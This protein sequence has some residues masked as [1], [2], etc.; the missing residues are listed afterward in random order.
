MN[1]S[2]EAILLERLKYG[3]V[4]LLLGFDYFVDV[5]SF[6][7][8]LKLISE[9]VGEDI[10][11]YTELFRHGDSISTENRF[12]K[13]K[14]NIDLIPTNNV[15]DKLSL[16]KWN[17]VYTSSVDDLILSRLKNEG[18]TTRPVCNNSKFFSYSRSELC[19]F[20]LFGL[21]SRHDALEKVPS[22]RNEF[23]KRKHESQLMLDTLADSMSPLDTL[24]ISGWNPDTDPVSSEHLYQV[25]SK[26]SQEQAYIFGKGEILQDELVDSLVEE[27]KIIKFE[28]TL[29]DFIS[30]NE[31]H[32]IDLSGHSDDLDSFIRVN[33]RPLEIPSRIRRTLNN[34]GEIVEDKFFNC[35][36]KNHESNDLLKDFLFESSRSPVWKAYPL[37][38]D[39]ER[40]Y[41]SS[42][43]SLVSDELKKNKVS[44]S[45]IILHGATGTGKSISL[46]RLCYILYNQNKYLILHI[47]NQVDTLDFKVIDEVCEW[48]ESSAGLITVICW[49]G[50]SNIDTYQNL[51]SY[52]SSRG[53]KQLVI[54]TTYKNESSNARRYINAPEQ[55]TAKEN[56]E[57]LRYLDR[58]KIS[59]ETKLIEFDSTFL[60]TLYR[61]LPETRFSITSGVV[62]EANH[63]KQL[64]SKSIKI[65][66]SCE[67]IIAEA[68]RKAFK[69]NGTILNSYLNYDNNV[70]INDIVD[71]VMIFG[72]FG[73]ETPL[74]V[75]IRVHP[76]LRFSNLS[77]AFKAVDIIR[78]SENKFGDINLSARNTLEAE[79]Y[80][81]RI[82]PNIRLHIEKLLSVIK[83]IE[84][85]N[86]YK[87]AEI[88]FC[89]EIIR[90][91]GPNGLYG[92]EY[93]DFYLDISRAI[94]ELL[95]LKKIDSPR[96]MLHQ[97]N[98]LREYGKRK[99]NDASVYYP[100]YYTILQEALNIIEK[101]I[102]SEEKRERPS[103]RQFSYTL[104]T[105]YG[106]K[107][108]ILGTLAN[109]CS[110]NN[111]DESIVSNYITEAISTLK[112][113]F[114]YNIANYISLDSIAW[115]V[116]N[117]SKSSNTSEADKLKVLLDAISIFNEYNVEDLEE[118][119][120][121]NFLNRK[122]DLYEKIGNETISQQT[123]EQLKI[124]SAEDYHYYKLTKLMSNINL[125][126]NFNTD[127]ITNLENALDYIYRHKDECFISYK[128]TVLHLRLFWLLE[129]K[130]PMLKGERV[131]IK[132]G[133][134]FWEEIIVLTQRIQSL[135]YNNNI[136]IYVYL[137]AVALFH[138]GRYKDSEILFKKLA[139]D[140]DSISGS[141]RVF[142]SFLMA[143][144]KGIRKFSGE[145][146]SLNIARNR[147]EIYIDEIN[148]KITIFPSDF[149]LSSEDKGIQIN[150]FHIAFNF[151]NPV[152]DNEK[153][154]KGYL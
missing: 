86:L 154:Y 118:R 24:V 108:S 29:P 67:N 18:R 127:N 61:L 40:E 100:E 83:C 8:V 14:H 4:F 27:K 73:I 142:K 105:L 42:L 34:Y 58:N 136:I 19:I 116:M 89:S 46:A 62:N 2:K 28:S 55:F 90:A 98:L 101:A 143:N 31:N 79:I 51:S 37:G 121:V 76:T 66:D 70:N 64:L 36:E 111:S 60:V 147:G 109:Q 91:F 132:K 96:L 39:F 65:A 80:C 6:N 20:Y 84:Q 82:I 114:K 25:I 99:Y 44:E 141:R 49:D 134:D 133:D 88:H 17:A 94:G 148:N 102:H 22:S 9:D 35:T 139:R 38:L 12:K 50:M 119:Y 15:L 135:A 131:I 137:K 85:K 1:D 152:A 140:S 122:T 110:N 144:E 13:I 3:R 45:P 53:R 93:Q 95:S 47:N 126:G 92:Q 97:A 104:I 75:I 149:N 5:Y 69:D 7:P 78:W 106:E 32:L 16:V 77:E 41:F 117:Y 30:R 23:I 107:A 87:S 138:L 26:L 123:L 120:R 52:L 128:I 11:S 10:N 112:E 63:I 21:Y 150:D 130:S 74:D 153:Y 33:D 124:V 71:I 145:I 146:I 129:N 48:A 103:N 151:I 68:F 72:K 115:I 125:T 54:G 57:F 43:F 113:S 81:K 56:I 59:L